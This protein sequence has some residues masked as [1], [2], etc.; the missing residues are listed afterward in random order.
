[1]LVENLP[2]GAVLVEME[3][4][5]LPFVDL[6][7]KVLQTLQAQSSHSAL[8]LGMGSAQ[9]LGPCAPSIQMVPLAL[10]HVEVS[11]QIARR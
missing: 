6:Q 10:A 8:G 1:M 5:T 4:K 11:T 9:C 3:A 2:P 7:E